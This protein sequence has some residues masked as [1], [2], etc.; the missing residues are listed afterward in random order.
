MLA[1]Y[2]GR[3]EESMA[4]IISVTHG[5]EFPVLELC[6]G[7]GP[8]TAVAKSWEFAIVLLLQPAFSH[9]P[10]SLNVITGVTS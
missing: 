4:I 6:D 2:L 5:N 10:A 3:H 1:E 9:R 7:A 8:S